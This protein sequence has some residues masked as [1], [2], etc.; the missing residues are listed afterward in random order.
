MMRRAISTGTLWIAVTVIAPGKTMAQMEGHVEHEI[1]S[2]D[3]RRLDAMTHGNVQALDPI[4]SRELVY[5]HASGWRQTKAELLASIESGELNYHTFIAHAASLR[6]YGNTVVVSG[7]ASAKVAA[8]GQE[9]DVNLL[10]LEIYVRQE[11]RWQLVAWQ[12]TRSAP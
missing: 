7:D 9:L 12:S 5:T 3:A 2:L 10:F 1:R 8:K 11:G 6:V 4:L